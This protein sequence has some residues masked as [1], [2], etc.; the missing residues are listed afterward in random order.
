M[1]QNFQLSLLYRFIARM[2]TSAIDLGFTFNEYEGELLHSA[3][4]Y[5][6]WTFLTQLLDAGV[7]GTVNSRDNRGLTPLHTAA[8][9]GSE[10]CVRI[11]L[12]REGK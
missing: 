1:S 9:H 6:Q 10:N 2:S 3:A 11:L 7:H 4:I 5:D 8:C 12:Q